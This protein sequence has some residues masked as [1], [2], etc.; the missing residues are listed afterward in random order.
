MRLR[1]IYIHVLVIKAFP[2]KRSVLSG[3]PS[4]LG[5]GIITKSSIQS[6]PDS[7]TA[8]VPMITI[9]HYLY[10]LLYYIIFVY[11]L[12]II[13]GSKVLVSPEIENEFISLCDH[14]MLQ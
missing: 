9:Q 13:V 11:N 7:A 12:P 4:S 5:F 2:Q 14:W 3:I 6:N 10:I 1:F 8:E